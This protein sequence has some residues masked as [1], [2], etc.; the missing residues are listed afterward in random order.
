VRERIKASDVLTRTLTTTRRGQ[1]YEL[2]G[3][4]KI[5]ENLLSDL[6][7]IATQD[8]EYLKT[9]KGVLPLKATRDT[10]NRCGKS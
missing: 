7:Q 6:K 5:I 3:Q 8:E 2:S 4:Y 10:V 9:Q 1:E